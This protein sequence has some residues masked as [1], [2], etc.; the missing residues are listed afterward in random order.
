MAKT[1]TRIK[2]KGRPGMFGSAAGMLAAM[3]APVKAMACAAAAAIWRSR[4]ARRATGLV[5]GAGLCVVAAWIML[6]HL[7]DQARFQIDPGRI[8]LAAMPTWAKPELA[9]RVKAEIETQLR[10]E[11]AAEAATDIFDTELPQ[12]LA[13]ALRR[14]PWVRDVKSVE[15]RFP[16]GEQ[17]SCLQPVLEV[18]RPALMVDCGGRNVLVDG[19]G[20]VLPLTVGRTP[21]DL[22]AFHA[23][24][25][26]PVRTVRGVR[27]VVPKP[28]EAWRSEQVTAAL[29]M[30]KVLRQSELDNAIP[31]EAIEL[32][33]V[34]EKA[35]TR[36]RVHYS[37]DGG[38]LLWPDQSRYP[39]TCLIWGRPPAHAGTSTLE[40]SP[41]EKL[42][43]LRRKLEETPD[44]LA[45]IRIDL[46]QRA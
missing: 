30:E 14:S 18:R 35:D 24:L 7:R 17:A 13:T 45:G 5:F 1:R 32:V 2:P 22:A 9:A 39:G 20:V 10:T 4:A 36:N 8:E 27:S 37:T 40:A 21:E 12:K 43:H 41:N 31:I 6:N 46:R 25:N 44:L 3:L 23:Q 42:A 34:P 19:E 16:S 29:S 38:V 28:G 33:G 11:L 15:R 26:A